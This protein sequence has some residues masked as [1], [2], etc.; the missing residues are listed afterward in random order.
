MCWAAGEGPC[1]YADMPTCGPAEAQ[2]WNPSTRA[3]CLELDGQGSTSVG[4]QALGGDAEGLL[5]QEREE[6]SIDFCGCRDLRDGSAEG[7][8]I[9]PVCPATWKGQHSKGSRGR[10]EGSAQAGPQ[11]TLLG[12]ATTA[13]HQLVNPARVVHCF[14]PKRTM[15]SLL[16]YSTALRVYSHWYGHSLQE[17]ELFSPNRLE[18]VLALNSC[19]SGPE[20]S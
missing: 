15:I 17:E 12:M 7:E 20:R 4:L 13:S 1:G 10:L 5:V 16:I 3:P 19:L 14:Q 2:D 6:E 9:S 8:E 18:A 11:R